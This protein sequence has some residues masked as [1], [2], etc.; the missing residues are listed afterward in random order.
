MRVNASDQA[1]QLLMASSPGELM[2]AARSLREMALDVRRQLVH[3]FA[4]GTS[5]QLDP[6]VPEP[7]LR[8]AELADLAVDVVTAT[9]YLI[10]LLSG[11]AIMASRLVLADPAGLGGE[12]SSDEQAF[13]RQARR[14]LDARGAAVRLGTRLL[15][16]LSQD[17]A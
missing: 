2:T 1:E 3:P 17:V 15:S 5:L 16:Q 4:P 14:Q 9:D 6:T 11:P 7:E 13:D 10:R 12:G 8:R